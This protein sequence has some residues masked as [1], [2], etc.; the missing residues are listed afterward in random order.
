MM[1]GPVSLL[2]AV[3]MLLNGLGTRYNRVTVQRVRCTPHLALVLYRP[4]E[5]EQD[6]LLAGR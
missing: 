3:D 2:K 1:R 6:D 4:V 5:H